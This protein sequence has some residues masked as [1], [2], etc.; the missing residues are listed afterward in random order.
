[1][2]KLILLLI[3]L[4]VVGL[5]SVQPQSLTMEEALL[6]FFEHFRC[7]MPYAQDNID[8][9]RLE[10]LE[11]DEMTFEFND[12]S[13]GNIDMILRNVSVT[14]LSTFHVPDLSFDMWTLN[15]WLYLEVPKLT[16]SGW[17]AMSGELQDMIELKG[18]GDFHLEIEGINLFM[19]SQL[20]HAGENSTW[21]M[22]RLSLNFTID[23][24]SGHMG[25]IMDDEVLEDFFNYLMV[26]AAPEIID[27]LWPDIEPEIVTYAK[28]M[29]PEMLNGTPLLE[30]I[31]IIF[32][33]QEFLMEL[34][35]EDQ[36]V[37]DL[38]DVKLGKSGLEP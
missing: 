9:P 27:E 26:N 8:L 22:N 34:P 10:P 25:G 31:N 6:R 24:I 3:A 11:E 33:D 36:C 19:D 1:M 29:V 38:G 15:F 16:M 21:W 18:S 28:D 30:L 4:A 7:R 12:D 23:Q 2:C 5:P 14:G 37:V 35:E 13:L 17:Y 32:L 20:G